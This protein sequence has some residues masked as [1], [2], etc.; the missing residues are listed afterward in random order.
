MDRGCALAAIVCNLSGISD[1]P[2]FGGW[3]K[4]Q[5]FLQYWYENVLHYDL[6]SVLGVGTSS[7]VSYITIVVGKPIVL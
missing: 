4:Q 6:L 2:H 3:Y 7:K 1:P 5:S